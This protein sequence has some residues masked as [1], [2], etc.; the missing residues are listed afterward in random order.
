VPQQQCQQHQ[1]TASDADGVAVAAAVA[2][3]VLLELPG[4]QHWQEQGMHN[5]QL[6]QMQH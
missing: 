2:L 4:C 3:G 6:H 5:N 1:G